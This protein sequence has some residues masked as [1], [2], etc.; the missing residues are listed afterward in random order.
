M[1]H[2]HFA[3]RGAHSHMWLVGLL[4]VAA[5]L[6]LVM[7][8]ATLKLIDRVP[9]LGVG[10]AIVGWVVALASLYALVARPVVH[11]VAQAH[12]GTRPA[13]DR[14]DFGWTPGM[15]VG[16]WIAALVA[17][18]V[19]IAV[20]V[21]APAWWPMA[22]LL[23]WVAAG[24]FAGF[25][26]ARAAKRSDV[27]VLP[28]VP[29]LSSQSALILD[30]GCGAGRTTL[31]V[32]RA[33]SAGE[34]V[35]LDRFDADYI[36]NGGRALLEHNVRVARIDHRVRIVQG[37][38]TQMPFAAETFDNAVS[39]HAVDHLGAQKEQG[40]RELHRVLKTGGTLL[41][42][43]WVPGWTTF[44]FANVLSLFLTRKSGWRRLAAQVGFTVRDEGSFNGFWYLVVEK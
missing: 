38:I 13:P 44:A 24:F 15:T 37:D 23:F 18:S 28:M 41:L 11:H 6:V 31:A 21:A 16:P 34:I 8:V 1:A 7:Y 14:Y 29:W 30:A 4:G 40:L 9:F 22:V 33:V 43:V 10:Y 32:G 36:D 42:V 20:G 2:R 26:I 3:H 17:A 35:A 12:G 27:A 5:G 19:G 39:T 25:L